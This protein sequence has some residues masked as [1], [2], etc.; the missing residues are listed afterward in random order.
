[1]SRIRW[2]R[3]AVALGL[4]P[5]PAALVLARSRGDE[6]TARDD[7]E[8]RPMEPLVDTILFSRRSSANLSAQYRVSSTDATAQG[9]TR[10]SR[11]FRAWYRCSRLP[12]S[13]DEI[14]PGRD[15]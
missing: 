13:K 4:P 7:A 14:L 5:P 12:G 8:G 1:R 9:G 15:Q 6:P 2:A 10:R 3:R 11:L